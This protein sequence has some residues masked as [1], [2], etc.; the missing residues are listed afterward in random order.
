MPLPFKHSNRS[1]PASNEPAIERAA[2]A[3]SASHSE[4]SLSSGSGEG[5]STTFQQQ[6]QQQQ[7]S[8]T[9]TAPSQ[10]FEL[11]YEPR[12]PETGSHTS[13][14]QNSR[15]SPTRSVSTQ[16][17]QQHIYPQEFEASPA[18]PAS[19]SPA[20]SSVDDLVLDT[21][22]LQ[23]QGRRHTAHIQTPVVE[24][25]KRSI[26][27]LMRGTNSNRSSEQKHP[28]NTTQG[29]HSSNTGG[30]ARRLSRR[31]EGPP[32]I[33]TSQQRDSVDQHQRVGWLPAAQASRSHLSSPRE[34]P[35]DDGLDPYLIT[36]PEEN[37]PQSSHSSVNVRVL[38]QPLNTI[39]AIQSDSDSPLFSA[40]SQNDTT[41][42]QFQQP[43]NQV[44]YHH[45]PQSA[46]QYESPKRVQQYR[47]ELPDQVHSQQQLN[48]FPSSPNSQHPPQDFRPDSSAQQY[49][50]S[51]LY[52]EEHRPAS[53]QSNNQSPTSIHQSNRVD[54]P[55]RTT[56]I[57]GPTP[58]SSTT[59][60]LSQPLS[61]APQS[62]TAQQNRR[63]ADSK[64][65]LQ[66]QM[67][68]SDGRDPPAYRQQQQAPSNSN[69]QP[70]A[71]SPLPPQG[72]G[73]NYRGGP[74]QREQYNPSGGGE[75]GRSTPPPAPGDRDVNEAYK[76]LS[77][78]YKKVKGLYFE[79]TASVEQ[80][81]GQVEQLQNSLANQRLSQSRT[82]LDDG[83]YISRFQRL[84]GAITNLAFN[85]R[86]DWRAVPAWLSQS[87]NRDAMSIG[88]QE[89]TAVGRACITRFLFD[90]IFNRTFHPGLE[91]EL[92]INLKSIEKNIRRF[93]P[94]I[95]NQEESDALTSKV[96]QWRLATLDGLKDSLG[97]PESEENKKQF[98]KVVTSNLTANLINYLQEPIPGG[99][100]EAATT[101]VE[102]AVSIAANIPLESRDIVIMY[103][104]PNDLVQRQ[105]MK[106]E[107]G[108]PALEHPVAETNGF[109]SS[110]VGSN[111]K[112][113][114][115]KE[116]QKS[117]A[118]LTKEKSGKGQNMLHAIMGSG[119][120][121]SG[122]PGKKMSI[123]SQG[124]QESSEKTK[125]EDGA[126]KVRFAG[127]MTIDVRGR[128]VLFSA[129]VW[130]MA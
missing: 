96:V 45:T 40:E 24:T 103:P 70:P 127:F 5:R 83:E 61:M 128:Q 84:D 41:E 6:Q 9:T 27:D 95:N 62:T 59:H 25:K 4:Q 57:Q 2:V 17:S 51:L 100:E 113:E 94:A 52:R 82:S 116:E 14:Y 109:D 47:Y 75:L 67:A 8:S 126:H 63:S 117:H 42:K 80:L 49:E 119:G 64:Q 92:S 3:P 65:I 44:Y 46:S 87:V 97:S 120:S 34:S 114:G 68:Q 72:Q 125:S 19:P 26:F 98:L 38:R 86:K 108:I 39:R 74:P 15:G 129:P 13:A 122:P 50:P 77:Q 36:N 121:G 69:N 115:S 28:P 1:K 53:V 20:G 99:I 54:Y 16:Y 12:N 18:S 10:N 124:G 110:S 11:P 76:E 7:S 32:V 111:D 21:Q 30:L 29:A 91:S 31:H 130:T 102:L 93:S 81:Q 35:E 43:P 37:S 78:K 60:P 33:R 23:N 88:K 48:S 105:T 73:P 58:G 55:E 118:K 79:K 89:M 22:R 71:T 56:S 104:M 107:T 90:E 123:S 66:A 85:I 106:V 101:I 112:D